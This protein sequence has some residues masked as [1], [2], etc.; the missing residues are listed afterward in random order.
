MLVPC[1][2]GPL[3]SLCGIGALLVLVQFCGGTCT[4][5]PVP[6]RLCWSQ[7]RPGEVLDWCQS[8]TMCCQLRRDEQKHCRAYGSLRGGYAAAQPLM[9]ESCHTEKAQQPPFGGCP[10]IVA[11][12]DCI[13]SSDFCACIS[14]L[15][16][17]TGADHRSRA[18]Q[19]TPLVA[20][21]LSLSLCRRPKEAVRS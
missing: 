5:A 9:T 19:I 14:W 18:F 12:D 2:V 7:R 20:L 21:S 16:H 15:D 1:G 13:D 10:P 3:R 6:L 11:A 4:S 17:S 8:E